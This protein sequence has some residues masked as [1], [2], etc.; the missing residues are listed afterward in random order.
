MNA[1]IIDKNNMKR[2]EV[3]LTNQKG[4]GI[5]YYMKNIHQQN[6]ELLSANFQKKS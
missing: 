2:Q 6:R 3:C 5:D 1:E 4:H